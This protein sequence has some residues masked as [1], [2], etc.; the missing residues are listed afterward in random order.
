[1]ELN[2]ELR[3]PGW[4]HAGSTHLRGCAW[5]DGRRLDTAA[6]DTAWKGLAFIDAVALVQACDGHFAAV[7][8]DDSGFMA[9]CDGIRSVPLF[10]SSSD[11]R[12]CLSDDPQQLVNDSDNR[13][14]DDLSV[15]EFLMAG[16]VSNRY[17]LLSGVR[18]VQA[19][20]AILLPAGSGEINCYRYFEFQHAEPFDD[21]HEIIAERWD[22]T[23]QRVIERELEAIGGR[24]VALPLS[25]GRDSRL[26]ALMLKRIGYD[27]VI[28]YG[29]GQPGNDESVIAEQ[30]ASRLGYRWEFVPYSNEQWCDWFRLP[31]CQHLLQSA[32]GM[33]SV[34]LL[35]DWPAVYELQ[36]QRRVPDDAVFIPGHSMDF[37]AG[38][39]IPQD[40]L[41][42]EVGTARL[43]DAIFRIQYSLWP[44]HRVYGFR[45]WTM[46]ETELEQQLR[47]KIRNTITPGSHAAM[48]EAVSAFE[49][50]DWQERQAKFVANAVRVYESF[51]FDWMLPFWEREVLVFW[52]HVS[53]EW[54][55]D[56]QFYDAYVIGLDDRLPAP[57]PSSVIGSFAKV[58]RSLGIFDSAKRA[59]VA[60][61]KARVDR[62]YDHPLGWYGIVSRDRFRELY[63]GDEEIYSFLALAQLQLL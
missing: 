48:A 46:S 36:R 51:G 13:Q 3:H 53:L 49:C 40:L 14:L 23:L 11:D 21:S 18:Q 20:E 44:L 5:L 25:G 42:R 22:A 31:A 43:V 4:Q 16:Q 56:K 2:L 17:T 12:H 54:R 35:Q 30:V 7:R 55:L 32:S 19:G 33:T 38:S 59:Y 26:I 50:W 24:T 27:N 45:D 15:A 28:C 52:Q 62:V 10:Y 1:M 60:M 47:D 61:R 6:L 9:V 58:A 63:T 37:L 39:H 29:Y 57:L 34:V 41:R 8:Q